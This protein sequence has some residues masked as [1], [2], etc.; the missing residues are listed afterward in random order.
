MAYGKRYNPH[1]GKKV[2]MGDEYEEM[3]AGLK[4]SLTTQAFGDVETAKMKREMQERGKKM[5]RLYNQHLKGMAPPDLSKEEKR[6]ARKSL[7]P[8]Q[9]KKAKKARRR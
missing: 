7:T 4:G 9:F 8:E 3:M 1:G 5:E 2:A 6:E